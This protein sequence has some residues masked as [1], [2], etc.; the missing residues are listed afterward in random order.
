MQNTGVAFGMFQNMSTL[1]TILPFFVTA[2][3]IYYYTQVPA[4]DWALKMAL[5]MQMGGAIGN[6]IDRLTLG[7]VVDFFSVGNF[8]VFNVADAS[9][10]GGVGILLLDMWIQES[11]EKAEREAASDE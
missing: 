3:I 8:P 2:L 6:L 1:F 10:T 11:R 4:P 9:I 5:S 7:Y